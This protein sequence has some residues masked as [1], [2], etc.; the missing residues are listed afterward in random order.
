MHLWHGCQSCLGYCSDNVNRSGQQHWS[1]Q[2][3][4]LACLRSWLKFNF[5]GMPALELCDGSN[6]AS[7]ACSHLSEKCSRQY[8]R[9]CCRYITG[10]WEP[11]FRSTKMRARI[12]IS[13]KKRMTSGRLLIRCS[14]L[15]VFEASSPAGQEILNNDATLPHSPCYLPVL[16]NCVN[17]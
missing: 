10:M 3:L 14:F 15:G 17:V 11:G 8:R 7:D 12:I 13:F 5:A 9:L 16:G 6:I 1:S 2:S 4:P